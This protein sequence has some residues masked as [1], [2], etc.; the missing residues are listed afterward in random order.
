MKFILSQNVA[1]YVVG[2]R[3]GIEY[4]FPQPIYRTKAAKP[5]LYMK[6]PA[7]LRLGRFIF[8][9]ITMLITYLHGF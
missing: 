2:I 1:L 3:V 5:I 6:I 8:I 7:F 9:G 4:K